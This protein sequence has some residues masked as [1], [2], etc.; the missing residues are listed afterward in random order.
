MCKVVWQKYTSMDSS[1]G[2]DKIINNNT[3]VTD[4][5]GESLKVQRNNEQSGKNSKNGCNG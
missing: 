1:D 2:G 4:Y 3:E 5:G